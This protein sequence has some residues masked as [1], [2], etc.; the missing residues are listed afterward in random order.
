[1]A[2]FKWASLSPLI[3]LMLFL[4]P[5]LIFQLYRSFMSFSAFSPGS[6][7]VW[8]ENFAEV[9]WDERFWLAVMRSLLFAAASTVLSFLIGFGLAFLMREKFRGHAFFYMIFIIPMLVVPVVIG[10][11]FEMLL[12][13]K[14]P[15]NTILSFFWPNE[16]MVT[17]L[18]KEIPAFLSLIFIE[19][20]NWTPFVFIILLAGLSGLPPEPNEAASILGASRARIFWEIELPSMRPVIVLVL[21]LRF[22]EGLAEFPKNQA[23]TQGGPGTS[24]ETIPVYLYLTSWEY[25]DLAKGFAM[26]YVT[27]ILVLAIVLV[28]VRILMKEKRNLDALYG[29]QP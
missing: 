8:F 18:S 13:S 24:T 21:L 1:M 20:W 14:G 19:V 15:V 22:L 12:V 16:V 17:W 5:V 28:A 10:Y 3:L 11:T 23:L 7:F 6:E 25:T 29:Q 27:L 9:L 4:M 26:S 2:L